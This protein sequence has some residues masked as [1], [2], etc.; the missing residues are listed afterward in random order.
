MKG[1]CIDCGNPTN[2]HG[3]A[4]Y[5]WECIRKG[6]KA[7]AAV[8]QAIKRGVLKRPSEYSCCDCGGAASQYDHRDYNNPLDVQPVC[9]RCNLK[10][11]PAIPEKKTEKDQKS[12]AIK[13]A[14][15]LQIDDWSRVN[16]VLSVIGKRGF[17]KFINREYIKIKGKEKAK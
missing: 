14:I 4:K 9:R 17:M 11:G 2:R 3:A 13:S 1:A 7:H 10:R 5:C 12:K 6:S 15:R 16:D 8:F